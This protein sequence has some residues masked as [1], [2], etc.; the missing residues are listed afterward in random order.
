MT[1]ISQNKGEV[2]GTLA[3]ISWTA[4]PAAHFD[5]NKQPVISRTGH[6]GATFGLF[7]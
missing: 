7:I 6:E 2:Q 3:I 4:L 1:Q 5:R